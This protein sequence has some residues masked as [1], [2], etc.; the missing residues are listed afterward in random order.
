MCN[1]LRS[2]SVALAMA[3][4]CAGQSLARL[5]AEAD[6]LAREWRQA[7]ALADLQDSLRK[8]GAR[9]GRDTIRAGGLTILANPSPLPVAQAAARAWSEIER[10]YGPAAPSVTERPIV[11]EA[12]DPDTT[13][14]SPPLGTVAQLR[15]NMSR[16]MMRQW[17]LNFVSDGAADPALRNWLGGPLLYDTAAA[18]HDAPSVYVELVTQPWGTVRRCFLGDIPACQVA[19]TLGDTTAPLTRRYSVEERRSLVVDAYQGFF[20]HGSTQGDFHACAA[21]GDSACVHLL[22]GL[23]PGS[24]LR[25]LDYRARL[26]L[27]AFALQAGGSRAM[28]R[29]LAAPD[30]TVAARLAMASGLS[31]DSLTARWLRSIRAARPT[32][33]SLPPW[34]AWLAL[35]WIGVFATCGLRSSRWRV[36]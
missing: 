34:G 29:L 32:P 8:L 3:T 15:W 26:S 27:V 22:Q 23:P 9:A 13:V 33:V 24:L 14:S 31:V 16:P 25:L 11:I 21:G 4:P 6:S 2:I 28:G 17:L 36:S 35:G 7:N 5:Q 12:I 1:Q 20:N 10:L 30:Q 18:A 19:L